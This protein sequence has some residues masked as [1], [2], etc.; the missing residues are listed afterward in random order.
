M[1]KMSL[2]LFGVNLFPFV[3]D[4]IN[5]RYVIAYGSLTAHFIGFLP[6]S[7]A[8]F[9]LCADFVY[10]IL[11]PQL[12]G[13]VYCPYVNAYGSVAAYL[14]GFLLRIGGGEHLEIGE[15]KIK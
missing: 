4:V 13:V 12:V 9:H 5:C 14:I 15:P 8:L 11:F 2:G 10:V 7:P 6:I 1:T 3:V